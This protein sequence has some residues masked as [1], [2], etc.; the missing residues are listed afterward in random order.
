MQVVGK[1]SLGV[2]GLY[3]V[4]PGTSLGCPIFKKREE[5]LL[6]SLFSHHY[7]Y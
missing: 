2:D 6:F 1:S 3:D 4:I 5:G 7:C